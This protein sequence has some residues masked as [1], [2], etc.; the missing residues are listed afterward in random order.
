MT[1]DYVSGLRI[2]RL[3]GLLS[4]ANA[5]F[6]KFEAELTGL[7][8]KLATA[9]A[10]IAKLPKT[11]DGVPVVPGIIVWPLH[12]LEDELGGEIRMGLY[13]RN[14]GDVELDGDT[15]AFST[16]YSTQAAAEAARTEGSDGATP[17]G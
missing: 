9:D 5:T 14:T 3:R 8:A 15:A 11:A 10:T 13:D 2:A 4:D 17:H 7:R 6:S 1:E 16:C 12:E